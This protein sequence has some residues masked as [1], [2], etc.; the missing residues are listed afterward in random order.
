[1]HK[2]VILA[3]IGGQGILTL[4]AIIDHA[5]MQ[6]ELYIKQAEV[7]GM[8]QRG[9]AV[10][11]HLRISDKDI[12]S[13][14]IQKGKTDMILSLELMESLRYLPYL[15]KNGIII[16]ATETVQNIPDYPKEELLIQ[17]IKDSGF[18]HIFIDARKTA[19]EAGNVRTE[20]VVMIGVASKFLGIKKEEF[21]NSLKT[22]FTNKGDDIVALNLRAFDLGE[23]LAIEL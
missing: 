17:Q 12:Y 9:G 1:M 6:S 19:K 8:S 21:Q 11:S 3:G 22:L 18:K 10:Q 16:T 23:E 14:L 20:N 4:A 7:H 2:N 5:A 13:D 15:S